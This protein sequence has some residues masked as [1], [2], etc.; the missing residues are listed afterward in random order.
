[1]LH[2]QEKE[3]PLFSSDTYIIQIST[4]PC[5][6]WK[7]ISRFEHFLCELKYGHKAISHIF[8]LSVI[9]ANRFYLCYISFL[10]L[11]PAH[12]NGNTRRIE[13]VKI[14]CFFFQNSECK[15]QYKIQGCL[16]RDCFTFHSTSD[17]RR[18]FDVHFAVEYSS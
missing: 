4:S 15:D 1:M 12:Q 18:Y 6:D 16:S 14:N 13:I 11:E 2:C 8:P 5:T 7:A 9:K 17:K 10:F 3:G